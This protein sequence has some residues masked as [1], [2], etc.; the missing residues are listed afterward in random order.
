MSLEEFEKHPHT[1]IGVVEKW[2]SIRPYHMALFFCD[3]GKEV[4]Y[5]YLLKAINAMAYKLFNMDLRKGDICVTSLPNSYEHFILGFACM[6]LGVMWCPLDLSLKPPEI[7]IS[8]ALIRDNI[9]MY[10]HLGKTKFGNFGTIG[11]AIR[12]NYP[13]LHYVIQ[14]GTSYE[15][16]REGILKGHELFNEAEIEYEGALK[17]K[18]DFESYQKE[19][20]KVL[21]TDPILLLFTMGTTAFPKPAMLTSRGIT[22]QNMCLSS[23]FNITGEDRMLVNMPPAF[24]GGL[25]EQLMTIL[26]QGGT[27]IVLGRF[28]AERSLSA[29]QNH[30]VTCLGQIPASYSME[31][32][33]KHYDAYDLS[34]LKHGIYSGQSVDEEFLNNLAKM[35][36]NIGTGLGLTET[37]GLC[38]YTPKKATF[39][40]I[41]HGLGTAFPI[42]PATIRAQMK[43]DGL[44]GDILEDGEIGEICFEGPQ[45]F[46]G[47]F[48]YDVA[49]KEVLSEDSVL[50]TGDMGF[51]DEK[52]IHLAGRKKYMINPK[53]YRV[54]QPEIEAYV[55][56][57]PEVEYVGVLGAKHAIFTEAVVAYIKVKKGAI[58]TEESINNHCKEMASYKRPSLIVFLEDFP[59]TRNNKPDYVILERRL[60]DDI[61]SARA[62]GKWD[63]S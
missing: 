47:Y 22:C 41:S 24:V 10:C 42:Y 62:N 13:W 2:A 59:L 43:E 5:K 49:T 19:C 6:K 23:A 36:P 30:R 15:K 45:T 60:T 48:N 34:S 31:W 58:L 11:Y 50:Y 37:S 1:L 17:K 38:T 21:E 28:D 33:L 4:S 7:M 27:A 32:N 57:L 3:T 35:A 9:K 51:K 63:S 25:T 46:L 55:S 61:N 52:G 18:H 8:L 40:D 16:Y 39:D 20:A 14:F 29:I 44:A 53:G 12:N 56:I 26:F 54:F